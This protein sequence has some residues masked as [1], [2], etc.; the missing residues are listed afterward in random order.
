MFL[1]RSSP[2]LPAPVGF[3]ACPV[4]L[5]LR[6]V[7]PRRSRAS[8]LPQGL[9]YGGMLPTWEVEEQG[10]SLRGSSLKTLIRGGKASRLDNHLLRAS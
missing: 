3:L 8:F 10:E 5:Q 2:E 9:A 6:D 7:R 1:H 4:S